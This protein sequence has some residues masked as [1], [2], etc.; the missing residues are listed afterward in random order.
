MTCAD[1]TH[2]TVSDLHHFEV[3]LACAAFGASPVHRH[4]FPPRARRNAF[5]RQ[6]RRLVIHEAAD[7]AHPR[8]VLHLIFGHRM[9]PDINPC[10]LARPRRYSPSPPPIRQA[11]LAYKPISSPS[12]RSAVIRSRSSPP[13]QCRTRTVSSA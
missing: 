12:P 9:G 13:S 1:K 4:V 11:A 7:E 8:L 2:F 10:R 5:V 6:A 3:F